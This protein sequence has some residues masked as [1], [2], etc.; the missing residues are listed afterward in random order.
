VIR[1]TLD[2]NTLASGALGRPGTIAEILRRWRQGLLEIVIS[3]HIL[4][5]LERTLRKPYFADRID[6]RDRAQFLSLLRELATVV[7]I[8]APVPVVLQDHAGNL[9]LATAVSANVPYIITGDREL[10]MLGEFQ[11][12]RIL[13]ARAFQSMVEDEETGRRISGQ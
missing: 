13:S 9:I 1:V 3:D 8:A 2:T 4:E 12:I 10:Q 5:E 6:P 7:E 11:Q